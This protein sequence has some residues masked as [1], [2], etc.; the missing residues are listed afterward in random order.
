MSGENQRDDDPDFL[1]DDF[2]LEDVAAKNEE[3]DQLFET[4]SL[5]GDGHGRATATDPDAEDVLFTAPEKELEPDA[6][7]APGPAFAESGESTW[8]GEGLEL[9]SGRPVGSPASSGARPSPTP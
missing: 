7:F 4:P 9:E 1:D 8:S 6:M 5:E 2:I 3:L